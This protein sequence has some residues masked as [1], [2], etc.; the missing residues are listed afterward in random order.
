[1]KSYWSRSVPNSV[2][3]VTPVGVVLPPA[4]I[5]LVGLAGIL[6]G[7]PIHL[8]PA[9]CEGRTARYFTKIAP[10]NIGTRASPGARAEPDTRRRRSGA[11]TSAYTPRKVLP[12]PRRPSHS[13][14]KGPPTRPNRGPGGSRSRRSSEC[15]REH[16]SGRCR[17]RFTVIERR[18]G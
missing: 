2:G 11:A 18:P 10:R 1:M 3:I 5:A 17:F 7:E 4:T 6:F 14:A 12:G 9:A 8:S 16:E 13:H 15:C